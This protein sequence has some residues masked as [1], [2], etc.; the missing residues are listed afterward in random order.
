MGLAAIPSEACRAERA[1]VYEVLFPFARRSLNQFI[2]G[3]FH[4]AEVRCRLIELRE[5]HLE[6]VSA[7]L[8]PP[9]WNDAPEE[10]GITS[11]IAYAEWLMKRDSKRPA[12]Q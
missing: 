6:D 11:S 9:V 12:L 4:D 10:E 1:F 3:H 8:S 5:N 7:D 2:R